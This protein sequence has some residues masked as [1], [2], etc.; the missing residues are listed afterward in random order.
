M[1]A[2]SIFPHEPGDTV[3][4]A[5]RYSVRADYITAVGEQKQE[6]HLAYTFSPDGKSCSFEM[7]DNKEVLLMWVSGNQRLATDCRIE[8]VY[9]EKTVPGLWIKYTTLISGRRYKGMEDINESLPRPSN[10]MDK[11]RRVVFK[12]TSKPLRADLDGYIINPPYPAF[13]PDEAL[14]AGAVLLAA[15]GAL[16]CV[17]VLAWLFVRRR[18]LG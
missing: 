14:G 10:E 3:S 5:L 2:P 15:A 7:P 6:P 16:L 18:R 9:L 13:V 1:D 4:T 12:D 11:V 17:G 8:Y